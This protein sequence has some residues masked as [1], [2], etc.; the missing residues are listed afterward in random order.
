M[1]FLVRGFKFQMIAI[2]TLLLLVPLL[3]VGYDYALLSKT[4][5]ILIAGLEEELTVIVDVMGRQIQDQIA[6]EMQLDPDRDMAKLLEDSF[7]DVAAP[8]ADRHKGVRIGL[9]I[10]SKDHIITQ[11]YLHDY[12]PPGGEEQEHRQQRVYQETADGIKAVLAGGGAATMLG[13]TWDDRFLEYLVPIYHGDQLVAVT[14]AEKRMHPVFAKS[15]LVRQVF[16]FAAMAIFWLAL[17]ATIFSTATMVRRVQKIKDG[18]EGLKTD[19]HNTLPEQPGELGEITRAINEM[20]VSLTEKEHLAKQLRRSER[21]A[22]LGRTV[23]DI[24]HELRNPVSIIQ[25]TVELMEPKSRGDEELTECLN[26]IKEQLERQ[27]TLISDLLNFGKP[28]NVEMEPINL[29]LLMNEIVA[30][31]SPLLKKNQVYLNYVSDEQI[32][33]VTGNREKLTQVFMNL[34]MNAIQAMPEGGDLTIQ[35]FHKENSA[36]VSFRDNGEGIPE[37]HLT[38]IFEPFYSR[39]AGGSGLGL[40][41]SKRIIEIHRGTISVESIPGED[42][43]FTVCFPLE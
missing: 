5:D 42:T 21:L 25:A 18:L 40:A 39:K 26:M 38:S 7:I 12:R 20:A 16:V 35:V 9:Y 32:P 22:T 23:T 34:I 11:G 31:T 41:I 6:A 27:N 8:L 30:I 17:G 43:V 28:S 1:L 13:E 15:A 19:F 14:W 37:D 4:D 2:V 33:V 3:V 24:A 29:R 36:C 10:V